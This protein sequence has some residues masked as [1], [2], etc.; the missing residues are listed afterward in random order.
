MAYCAQTGE[1]RAVVVEGKDGP[2]FDGLLAD[3]LKFSQDSKRVAYATRTGDKYQVVVDDVAGPAFEGI[4]NLSPVFSPDGRHI[5]Y[6]A[7]KNGGRVQMADLKE[8]AEAGGMSVAHFSPDGNHVAFAVQDGNAWKMWDDGKLGKAFDDVLDWATFSP[9]SQHLAYVA[10]RG[11]KRVVVEDG[12]ES[13]EY[14]RLGAPPVFGPGGKHLVYPVL[15]GEKWSMVTDGKPGEGFDGIAKDSIVI[16]PD[17]A[18]VGYVGTRRGA[19]EEK[20]CLV[21]DSHVGPPLDGVD[22][23][24]FSPDGKSVGACERDARGCFVTIDGK[25]G[26]HFAGAANLAFSPDS[27]HFAYVAQEGSATFM[28]V[29]GVA[30]KD[31]GSVIQIPPA[32]TTFASDG[33]LTFLAEKDN[34]LYRMRVTPPSPAVPTAAS[35]PSP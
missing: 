11:G 18:H 9:D 28:V 14:D 20:E 13:P 10:R 24:V 21:V 5:A 25:Q 6:V 1:K 33:S 30:L 22:P 7:Q 19:A 23:P 16:S 3:T 35:N 26:P 31:A 2:P 32:K 4:G 15:Q 8:V 34:S 12:V 27:E 29:D 17:G